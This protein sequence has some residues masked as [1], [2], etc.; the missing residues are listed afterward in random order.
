MA[1]GRTSQP[2]AVTG[3]LLVGGASRRFGT[4]KALA[5]LHGRTLAAH[6]WDALEWCDERIAVGKLADALPLPFPLTDD[7][8]ELRAPLAGLVAGL[9]AASNDL[10]VVLAVDFP[11]VTPELLGS[12]AAA[13][14]DAAAAVPQTGPLPG[15]YRRSSLPVFEERLASG[16]LSIRGALRKL[17][18]VTTNCDPKLLVNVNT[19]AELRAI[20]PP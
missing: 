20:G 7:D 16:D 9:R 17:R 19:E 18:T 5:P 2:E 13:C 1:A 8:S 4:P 3:V 12:L 14:S 11:L 6:A 15:A 10:C